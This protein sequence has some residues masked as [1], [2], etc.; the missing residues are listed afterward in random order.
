ML[1]TKKRKLILF[2]NKINF[3]LVLEFILIIMYHFGWVATLYFSILTTRPFQRYH[4]YR[5][6][7]LAPQVVSSLVKL[8]IENFILLM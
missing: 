5:N 8:T 4:S 3:K 2:Y 6:R 1:Y 7:R